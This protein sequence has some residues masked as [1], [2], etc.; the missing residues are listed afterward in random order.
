MSTS[1]SKIFKGLGLAAATAAIVKFGK[2]SIDAASELEEIQNVV[3]VAFGDA[4]DK[5]D[6]FA[7]NCINR[8][9]LSEKAAKS[10]ASTF[11]YMANGIGVSTDK[12]QTMAIQ[13]TGL[14]GDLASFNDTSVEAA[15]T[16]LEGI[17]TG[18]WRALKQYGIVLTEATLQEY[19][20]SQGI[21]K[22]IS[23]MSEAEKVTLRYNYVLSVTKQQQNDFVRTTNSWANQV[24]LLAQQFN[25]LKV[26][27]GGLLTKALLPVVKVL[28]VIIAYL[29]AAIRV[30]KKVFFGID[31]TANAISGATSGTVD[32]GNAADDVASG[33]DDATKA[34]KKLD[35]LISGFDELNILQV[36][37][38]TS[39]SGS[40]SGI[41]PYGGGFDVGTYFD[42]DEI[43][44]PNID[45]SKFEEA[46]TTMLE[47]I[48]G[49]FDELTKALSENTE[50]IKGLFNWKTLLGIGALGSVI[51]LLPKMFDFKW[52][53]DNLKYLFLSG[54]LKDI[55]KFII[56]QFG[57]AKD[58][59]DSWIIKLLGTFQK[60]PK[61]VGP[62]TAALAALAA[63]FTWCWT[64]S[65][66]FRKA[67]TDLWNTACKPFVDN[68]KDAIK[69]LWDAHLKPL[70][71]SIKQM[72]SAIGKLILNLGGIIKQLWDK[73]IAPVL[74]WLAVGLGVLLANVLA[75]IGTLI[76]NITGFV[77][78]V[79][80]VVVDVINRILGFVNN[81]LENIKKFLEGGWGYL[82]AFIVNIKEVITAIITG[83]IAGLIATIVGFWDRLKQLLA[84]I[85]GNIDQFC[86]GVIEFWTGIIQFLVGVFSL[87]WKNAWEGIVQ[88]FKG[89]FDMIVGI[90][91]AP[92]NLVIGLINGLL[93]GAENAARGVVSALN[94]IAFSFNIPDWVPF[95][96]GKSWNFGLNLTAPT[97]PRISYLAQGGVITDPTLAMVGEYAGARTNPEIVTPA[98]LMREVIMEGNDDLADVIIQVGRQVVEAIQSNETKITIGDDV[99]SAAAAR[100]AKNYKYRTGRNQFAV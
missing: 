46:F 49:K 97:L 5:I 75:T 61:F 38:D 81:F 58:V 17:Y 37:S 9:G 68:L 22:K 48:K 2:A 73:F 7:K 35:N 84:A 47:N 30:I 24:R 63:G 32:L 26:N 36:P 78:D 77:A 51:A 18:N 53:A 65:E 98:N 19:A 40:G 10:L 54:N 94:K 66:S 64:T 6:K 33:F 70:W 79:I 87:N 27:I 52:I 67:V 56:G 12:A 8:F 3:N 4:A 28:N 85:L 29:N 86:K 69:S 55:P 43:A 90:A 82:L 34:A 13:L 11:M 62:V 60:L 59:I 25:I 76:A 45:T 42:P 99:I 41:D 92:I 83:L 100:G 16:A 88:T 1:F 23:A 31:D 74:A 72:F 15:Q 95:V 89:I 39:G 21:R 96:G 57:A 50:T 93:A 20:Y 71:D 80:K 44:L 91:K 14:A